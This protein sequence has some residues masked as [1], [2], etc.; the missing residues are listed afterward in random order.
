MTEN[1]AWENIYMVEVVR[2]CPEMCRFC[3]ASYLTLPFRT[4]PLE[5]S[6]IP[7]IERGLKVTNRLGLLGASV[8]QHPEFEAILDYLSQSRYQDVR[9][10]I[11]SLRTNTL[12][13]KLAS[14]LA[15]RDTRSVTIAVE[16]GSEKVRQIV[17]KKLTN[18]E[19]IQAAI[20]AKAGGTK[21]FKALWHG[22][23]SWGGNERC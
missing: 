14:T 9:L 3:L 5:S 13:K 7:A 17:N 19:I 20:N 1:A 23:N 22:R 8:T 15:N 6:L 12:T 11:A 4:A 16:S 21:G 10:S 2:S 18:D